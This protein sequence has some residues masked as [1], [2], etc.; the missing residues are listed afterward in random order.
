MMSTRNVIAGSL[1]RTIFVMIAL[2]IANDDDKST[3]FF[4]SDWF[5]ITNLVLFSISNGYIST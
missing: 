3:Y 5:K 1:L 4:E 2:L